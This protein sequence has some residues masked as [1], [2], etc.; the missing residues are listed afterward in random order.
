MGRKADLHRSVVEIVQAKL[1][2][3]VGRMDGYLNLDHCTPKLRIAFS[4]FL[5]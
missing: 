3:E 5:N 2:G 4:E 1:N